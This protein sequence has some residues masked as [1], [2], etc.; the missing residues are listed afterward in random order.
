[1][2]AQ[3]TH[4]TSV[5]KTKVKL[6]FIFLPIFRFKA[7]LIISRKWWSQ[8]LLWQRISHTAHTHT[9]W[10]AKTVQM[11]SVS[12]T[13]IP[14]TLV[15]TGIFLLSSI[16]WAIACLAERDLSVK[17]LFPAWVCWC[18][19]ALPIWASS[20]YGGRNLMPHWRGGG[21]RKSILLTVSCWIILQAR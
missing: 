13:S 6:Y 7:Q 17:T 5:L 16:F 19:P 21:K 12:S 4:A 1:M 11:A 20:V 15:D 3:R 2:Q 10:L 9:A 14:T 8:C 18:F